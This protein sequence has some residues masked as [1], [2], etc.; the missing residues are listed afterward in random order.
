MRQKSVITFCLIILFAGAFAQTSMKV[1][2]GA[3][4]KKGQL[5]GVHFNLNDFTTP[6]TF[7]T[8][9]TPIINSERKFASI[10]DMSAGFSV[11]YWRGLTSLVDFSTKLNTIFY[12]YAA[13]VS[14]TTG[15]TEVGLELEPTINIRPFG[16]NNRW[17]PFLT[18]GVGVGMYTGKLGAYVPA[19]IGLQ[20]NFSSATYFF[21]QGQY[22]FTLTKN[23]LPDN[24]VYSIG[25]AES[26]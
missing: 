15:K 19:G 17:A 12:D 5:F 6:A 2:N 11:S 25:L 7:K 22:H 3:S 24:I 26:F 8:S 23:V 21:L 13:R 1:K 20:I 4:G 18:G 10:R 14:G 9:P 16:D